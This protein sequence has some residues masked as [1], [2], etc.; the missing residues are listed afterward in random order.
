MYLAFS[1]KNKL[2]QT[3]ARTRMMECAK[4]VKSFLTANKMKQNDWKTELLIL[5][6]AGHKN[7]FKLMTLTS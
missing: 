6:T 2:S 1:P 4:E 3:E 5:S 7:I